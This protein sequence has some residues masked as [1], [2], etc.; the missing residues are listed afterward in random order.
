MYC[1]CQYP[2]AFFSLAMIL[3]S[4]ETPF[5]TNP[6]SWFLILQT[7]RT[8][9]WG[10]V[11]CW[12]WLSLLRLFLRWNFKTSSIGLSE[13]NDLDVS[14]HDSS[15]HLRTATIQNAT[16]MTENTEWEKGKTVRTRRRFRSP[17]FALL[18]EGF[19]SS[20]LW[21]KKW[22]FL[23]KLSGT[24]PE[25]PFLGTFWT[26]LSYMM[27]S[28]V[29]FE[30][31]WI[32]TFNTFQRVTISGAHPSQRLSKEIC[33]SEGSLEV[34]WGS[35]EF[36]GVDGILRELL[37][38][39]KVMTSCWRSGGTVGQLTRAPRVKSRDSRYLSGGECRKSR[40][41]GDKHCQTNWARIF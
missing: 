14:S 32:L 27:K 10:I 37:W 31:L 35:E 9:F 15:H 33:F 22:A 38:K 13:L 11:F 28:G 19:R 41:N 12:C 4:T 40:T 8:S 2:W 36:S 5:A 39:I 17:D 18:E 7:F 6:F 30:P 1:W 29:W 26:H 3:D 24:T 20:W 34:C 25:S 23:G 21:R 16:Q